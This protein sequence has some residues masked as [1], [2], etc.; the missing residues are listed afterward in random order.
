[1]K[2]LLFTLCCLL[3][4]TIKITAQASYVVLLNGDTIHGTITKNILEYNFDIEVKSSSQTK[5]FI[6]GADKVSRIHFPS[7][8]LYESHT[9]AV[10]SDSV[11]VFF[12]CLVLGEMNLY[13]FINNQLKERFFIKKQGEG[14]RELIYLKER[15]VFED[16]DTGKRSGD[17]LQKKRLYR[18]ELNYALRDCPSK[19]IKDAIARSELDKHDI[20]KLIIDYHRCINQPYESF[21]N[22]KGK[23]KVEFGA[24]VGLNV[25]NNEE[26]PRSIGFNYGGFVN[27]VNRKSNGRYAFQIRYIRTYIDHELTNLEKTI[28]RLQFNLLRYS[29][30][31][32]NA[33]LYIKGGYEST[34]VSSI[35]AGFA[36]GGGFEYKIGKLKVLSELEYRTLELNVLSLNFGIKI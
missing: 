6:G 14:K 31:N 17:Y 8:K 10:E 19:Q 15:V 4:L 3:F 29:K 9:I 30:L 23:L 2:N 24:I 34:L 27:F 12:D 25:A 32:D 26:L 22:K 33:R 13:L 35:N 11:R 21:V 7:G 16:V 1:M 18:G 28:P 20:S 5:L 36:L